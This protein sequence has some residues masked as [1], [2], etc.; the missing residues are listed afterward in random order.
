MG[1]H[2]KGETLFDYQWEH[3]T[4]HVG[5]IYRQH[6]IHLIMSVCM[7]LYNYTTVKNQVQQ[8][9]KDLSM[10]FDEFLAHSLENPSLGYLHVCKI[11]FRSNVPFKVTVMCVRTQNVH[12]TLKPAFIRRTFRKIHLSTWTFCIVRLNDGKIQQCSL[13]NNTLLIL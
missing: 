1:Q 4:V 10:K 8:P 9:M 6:S 7:F 5:K 12:I 13:S 3:S 11:A 2:G